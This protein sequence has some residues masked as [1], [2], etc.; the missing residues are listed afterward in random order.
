MK[1]VFLFLLSLFSVTP[2]MAQ[3]AVIDCSTVDMNDK[4]P[5]MQVLIDQCK[6]KTEEK[7]TPDDVRE[8][9]SLGKEFSSAVVDTAKELG[10][11]VNEFLYTP[12]G[13]LIA[14]YFMWDMIGGIII[15]IPLLIFIW[16]MYFKVCNIFTKPKSYIEYE[17]VPYLWGAFYLKKAKTIRYDKV[18]GEAYLCWFILGF[19]AIILSFITIGTL[20]F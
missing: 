17:T 10:V 1:Y 20:I 3:Q 7:I 6:P 12:V 9:G 14:F 13:F 2:A 15:G 18:S 5:V 11:A 16:W 8:W 4:S 19:P